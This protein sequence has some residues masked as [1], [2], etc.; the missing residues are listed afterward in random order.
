MKNNYIIL[1]RI[2]TNKDKIR[3]KSRF[4]TIKESISYKL[5]M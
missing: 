3:I 2:P 1:N 4:V 5:A